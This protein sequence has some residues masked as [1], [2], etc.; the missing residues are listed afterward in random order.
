M[1]RSLDKS[2]QLYITVVGVGTRDKEINI[3]HIL[4]VVRPI[5]STTLGYEHYVLQGHP[6]TEIRPE[7]G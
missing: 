4:R 3:H 6:C 2:V 1:F 5:F 7:K